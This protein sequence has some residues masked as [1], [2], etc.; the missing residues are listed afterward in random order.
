MPPVALPRSLLRAFAAW[1]R[2]WPNHCAVCHAPSRGPAERLC[3]DCRA[4]FVTERPRCAGC[5]LALPEAVD[6][7]GGCLRA[8][9]PW[10]VAVAACDY[11]YPWRGLIGALKFREAIDLAAC[12]AERLGDAVVRQAA[13]C[14]DVLLPVPLSATRLRAR[15]YNQALLVARPLGRRLGVPVDPHG[16]VRVGDPPPQASLPRAERLANLRGAF[17]IDPQHAARWRGR[18]VAIVDDV[19]TTG[20][21]AAELTRLLRAAG[22]ASVQVWV[23]ARTPRDAAAA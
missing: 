7:C 15:G 21:T 10:T 5:A 17:A 14:P 16:L 20:A 1:R 23:V 3:D 13:P 12:L 18:A 9:P 19:M 2:R 6:V 8:P 11:G 4:R 22:A